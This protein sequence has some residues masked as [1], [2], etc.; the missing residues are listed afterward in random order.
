MLTRVGWLAVA[1]SLGGLLLAV[2]ALSYLLV[3]VALG[4]L[5]FVAADILAFHVAFP[6]VEGHRFDAVRS[7][8]PR[9]L[10]V[11]GE[12]R[13]TVRATYLGARGFWGELVDIVPEGCAVPSG[14]ARVT[15]WW[16][17]GETVTLDYTL[18]ALDRGRQTVGPTI[19]LAVGPLGL[20]FVSIPVCASDEFLGLPREPALPRDGATRALYSRV[21]GRL[22]LRRRGFGSEIRSLRAYEPSDDV[23]N[24][25]WRR[26][27]PERLLV[28]EY[29]QEGRQDYL[30]VFDVSRSMASG[31][32]GATA[33]DVAA[34]AGRLV[35]RL[36]ERSQEDRVGLLSYSG[37]RVDF[38]PLG[39]GRGH[40]AAV[41]AHLAL[42]SVRSG[43][44]ELPVLFD[45]L[46][47][48]LTRQTHVFVFSALSAPG[49][50][51]AL[52]QGRAA[53]RRHRLCFFTP[54]M[55]RAEPNWADD[56]TAGAGG[57]ALRWELDRSRARARLLRGQSLPTYAYDAR[58]VSS[59]VLSAYCQVRGWGFVR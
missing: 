59:R 34:S 31:P 27:T 30:L 16:A 35:A 8:V 12:S 21:Q 41:D 55:V 13:V 7:G 22:S 51:D 47:S 33:L 9:R 40:L 56:P 4:I 19:L 3:L 20:S 32:P 11:G 38:L 24:V 17:P 15:R 49:A 28:R 29:E 44:F 45:E 43:E 10:S 5:A 37:D 26:S 18:R 50:R 53:R 2:L 42:L 48:R 23:R 54:E 46:V 25:A 36:V 52:V 39:R 6:R 14:R 58:N 57:W 1:A